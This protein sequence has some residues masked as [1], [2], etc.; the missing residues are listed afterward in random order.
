MTV[1]Y[2]PLARARARLT[3][4]V[5]GAEVGLLVGGSPLVR[6][7]SLG[8]GPFLPAEAAAH[9]LAEALRAKGAD[10]ADR[11]VAAA[12]PRRRRRRGG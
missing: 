10:I 3:E 12:L 6:T 5:S 11:D 1:R 7:F 2:E 9:A 4:S 8:G